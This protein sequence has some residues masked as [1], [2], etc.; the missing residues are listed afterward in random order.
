MSTGCCEELIDVG[1]PRR[2]PASG[3]TLGDVHQP[4]NVF[5]DGCWIRIERIFRVA[6]GNA[7]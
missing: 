1:A 7:R 4:G 6:V 3:F 2:S 5:D